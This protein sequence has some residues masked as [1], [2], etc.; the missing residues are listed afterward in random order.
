MN[1]LLKRLQSGTLPTSQQRAISIHSVL[2]EAIRK[3]VDRQPIPTLRDR[4][5]DVSITADH[6][7]L[8][9]ILMH[10]YHD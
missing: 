8:I 7:Q 2:L 3:S 6:D 9:M 10:Q 5:D 4:A 1:H